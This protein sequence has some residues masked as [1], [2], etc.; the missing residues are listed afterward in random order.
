MQLDNKMIEKI[1]VL[2]ELLGQSPKTILDGALD[3]YFKVQ[4]EKQ[5]EEGLSAHKKETDLSY[6]E[7]WGDVDFE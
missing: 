4:K 1:E 6:D 5:L 7:F 3:L 2:S